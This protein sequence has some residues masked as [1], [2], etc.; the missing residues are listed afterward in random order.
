MSRKKI[1]M[2][3]SYKIYETAFTILSYGP[4]LAIELSVFFMAKSDILHGIITI[5]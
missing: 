5:I 2:Y 4:N 1:G 3:K